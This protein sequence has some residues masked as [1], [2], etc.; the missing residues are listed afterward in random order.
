MPKRGCGGDGVAPPTVQER[1]RCQAKDV[2]EGGDE[3]SVRSLAKPG[4]P[5]NDQPMRFFR[6]WLRGGRWLPGAWLKSLN[7]EPNSM[8]VAY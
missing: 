3:S 7:R 6:A 4:P 8:K 5:K 1:T 2:D